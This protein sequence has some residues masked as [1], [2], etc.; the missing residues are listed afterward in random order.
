[1]K[2]LK[3]ALRLLFLVCL[4]LL[5]SLGIGAVGGIPLPITDKRKQSPDINIELVEPEDE[6]LDM[7][8]FEGIM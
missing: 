4:I 7:K 6:K 8:E 3:K 2:R 5:A 1:M